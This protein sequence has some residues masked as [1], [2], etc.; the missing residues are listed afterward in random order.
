[1]NPLI[2]VALVVAGFIGGVLFTVTET[3]LLFLNTFASTQ[4]GTWHH[5]RFTCPGCPPGRGRHHIGRDMHGVTYCTTCA[6][7]PREDSR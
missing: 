6:P 3:G 2:A 1:M 5:A 4:G 7:P